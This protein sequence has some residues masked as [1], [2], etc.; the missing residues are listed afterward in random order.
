MRR[1]YLS[2]TLF[3]LALCAAGGYVLAT[4]PRNGGPLEE[5]EQAQLLAKSG[6]PADFPVHPYARRMPQ[7][8]QGGFSYALNVPV[9]DALA[10]ERDALLRAGYQ[11]F[12]SGVPGQDEYLS[13]WIFFHSGAGASGA[14]IVRQLDGGPISPTEV[15]V[16]SQQDAR[17]QPPRPSTP[18]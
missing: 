7:P 5:R 8:K 4:V 1:L 13:R 14:V 12:D 6:L 10:W 11:V 3:V 15:K 2:V 9:P 17:L 16:L 18:K